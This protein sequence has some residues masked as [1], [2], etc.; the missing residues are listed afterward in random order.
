[1]KIATN[2]E[3]FITSIN[4]HTFFYLNITNPVPCDFNLLVTLSGVTKLKETITKSNIGSYSVK[5]NDWGEFAL[6]ME[7]VSESSCPTDGIEVVLKKG[8]CFRSNYLRFIFRN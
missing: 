5:L 6:T 8:V 7:A 1:M 3:T 2:M 4:P